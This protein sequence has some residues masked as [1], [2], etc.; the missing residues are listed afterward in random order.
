MLTPSVFVVQWLCN[1]QLHRLI[2]FFLLHGEAANL[3]HMPECLCF[4]FYGMSH[5]LMLLDTTARIDPSETDFT[6]AVSVHTEGE[7]GEAEVYGPGDFLASIVAPIYSFVKHEVFDRRD[8]E[9]AQRVMYDDITECFWQ[10]CV[11][12][13]SHAAANP[14]N[15]FT[16]STTMSWLPAPVDRRSDP[17]DWPSPPLA[18]GRPLLKRLLPTDPEDG[19]IDAVNAPLTAY[20]YL[21]TLLRRSTLEYR[22]SSVAGGKGVT[23]HPLRLYFGKTYYEELGW[24]HCYHIFVRVMQWHVCA[25]HLMLA[26]AFSGWTW[27][28]AG[29][30][31][32]THAVCKILRQLIDAKIGHPPRSA[33]SRLLSQRS[34]GRQ[35]RAR[36]LVHLATACRHPAQ[37]FIQIR[38]QSQHAHLR[39]PRRVTPSTLRRSLVTASSRLCS[40]SNEHC[41]DMARPPSS[42][43]Y[44]ASMRARSL[45]GDCPMLNSCA[46]VDSC[47]S[48][49]R[50]ASAPCVHPPHP[51]PLQSLPAHEAGLPCAFALARE[52]R[53]SHRDGQAARGAALDVGHLRR[54]LVDSHYNQAALRLH[55]GDPAARAAHLWL[56]QPA[57][58]A[59]GH[60]RLPR[61]RLVLILRPR[62]ACRPCGAA[63]LRAFHGCQCEAAPSNLG[64]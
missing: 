36:P 26:I 33:S 23:A 59:S 1:A 63:P 14:R 3:R 17:V 15:V 32:I 28:A 45:A 19:S 62:R 58:L 41:R 27:H 51:L 61:A 9:V 56:A 53:E 16:G 47:A 6:P 44:R 4:I 7:G 46:S 54:L 10:R 2:L 50:R 64:P 37:P 5:A 52:E 60:G 55:A 30:T 12:S 11:L 38:P 8:D 13:T 40:S 21:R 31:C 24:S 57:L 49:T 18:C 43:S 25:F 35:V 34:H 29:T 48:V 20:H 22:K 42:T 39:A